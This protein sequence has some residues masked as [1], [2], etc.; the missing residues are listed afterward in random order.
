MVNIV[1]ATGARYKMRA[2]NIILV[3]EITAEKLEEILVESKAT[4]EKARKENPRP[5]RAPEFRPASILTMPSG[6]GRS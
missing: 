5:G 3:K 2:G 4:E 1:T 6:R